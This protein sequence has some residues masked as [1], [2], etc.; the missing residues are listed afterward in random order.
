MEQESDEM[1]KD[2]SSP[3]MFRIV[4]AGELPAKW[5]DRLA[6]MAI[7]INFATQ[8]EPARTILEGTLLDQAQLR[9]V[10]DLLGS[11]QLTILSVNKLTEHA[12]RPGQRG[13]GC[14]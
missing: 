6:G 11:L 7:S 9:G 1:D 13:T 3:A 5:Q 4:V 14:F 2:S 10:L 8:A 12:Y